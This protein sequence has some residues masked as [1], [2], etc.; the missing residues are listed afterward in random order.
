MADRN[1]SGASTPKS[2]RNDVVAAEKER[3]GGIKWGSAFF[4]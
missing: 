4:G 3:F 2:R 1:I